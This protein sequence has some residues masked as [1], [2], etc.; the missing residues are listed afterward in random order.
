MANGFAEVPIHLVKIDAGT[1]SREHMN[2]ARIDQLM[3]VYNKLPPIQAVFDGTY[4]LPTDGFHT[5]SAAV[6]LDRPT[7]KIEWT[8]GNLEDARFSAA[9]ANAEHDD[10]GMPRT[11]ADKRLCGT[12]ALSTEKGKSM[13]DRAL[14]EHCRIS[15][16]LVAI[17]RKEPDSPKNFSQV[18]SVCT[19]STEH[20]GEQNGEQK[21]RTG[22]DGKSY[23][24]TK[25]SRRKKTTVTST[26]GQPSENSKPEELTD[27]VG[28]SV[29]PG[30]ASVFEKA[31]DFKEII[32]QLNAINRKLEE[33]HKHPAGQRLRLQDAQIDLKNLKETVRFDAPYAVC[34]ICK[35]IPKNRKA[36]CPCKNLG[37]LIEGSYKNLPQECRV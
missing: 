13:S 17:L 32:N 23:P 7:V 27:Q 6:K 3:E 10:K 20:T 29:P 19:S 33:L 9:S 16:T 5:Y 37:W 21:R 4:Y 2:E 15:P 34:P 30:L 11:N 25:R 12:L 36:N 35:G 1:Q 22:K 24:S 26:N 8:S 31:K 28:Q 18:Q 14:A